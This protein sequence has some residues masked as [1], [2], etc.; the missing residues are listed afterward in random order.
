[1]GNMAEYKL[2]LRQHSR[3]DRQNE[4]PGA[5]ILHSASSDDASSN[6]GLGQP[7]VASRGELQE[8]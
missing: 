5:E 7:N 2:A 1:M 6:H 3:A 8:G 4:I